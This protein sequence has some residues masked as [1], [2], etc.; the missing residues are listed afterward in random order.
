MNDTDN[1]S[2]RQ[3]TWHDDNHDY[4]TRLHAMLVGAGLE[5]YLIMLGTVDWTV[6][7]SSYRRE[8][9]TVRFVLASR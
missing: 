3:E 2:L 4:Y 9:F 1:P 6:S 8:E 7:Q 5:D